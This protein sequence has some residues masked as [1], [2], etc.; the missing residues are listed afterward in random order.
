MALSH[1]V[2]LYTRIFAL[3]ENKVT[4]GKT[5]IALELF[6]IIGVYGVVFFVNRNADDTMVV[7]V[8]E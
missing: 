6:H 2:D 4:V 3:V 5:D 7:L 1:I 8:D